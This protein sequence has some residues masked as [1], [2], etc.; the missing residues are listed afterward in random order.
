MKD[1]AALIDCG[2]SE[3][4][5]EGVERPE[6]DLESAPSGR[7]KNPSS[8]MSA[9]NRARL[10]ALWPRG[11]DRK[12]NTRKESISHYTGASSSSSGTGD[13]GIPIDVMDSLVVNG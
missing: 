6:S 10:A 12:L 1:L 9:C 5:N 4:S 7:L 13:G 11:S 8:M 3:R 2:M